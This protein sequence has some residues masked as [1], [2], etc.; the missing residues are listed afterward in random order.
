VDGGERLRRYIER[1]RP[2]ATDSN[3]WPLSRMKIMKPLHI[4]RFIVPSLVLCVFTQ[5]CVGA[6]F[7]RTKTVQ[8]RDPSLGEGSWTVRSRGPDDTNITVYTTAWL[9]SHWGKPTTISH[10]GAA[11]SEEIWKYKSELNWNGVTLFVLVPIFLE[12]PLG[13]EQVQ[14]AIQGGRVVGAKQRS[15][16]A[17]GGIVGYSIGPC[18]ITPFGVHSLKE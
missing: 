7:T 14:L 13:K 15:T 16:Q 10:T 1:S 11:G 5:G 2:A 17:Y 18:G 3:R 4:T 9:E 12:V 8:I 6:G